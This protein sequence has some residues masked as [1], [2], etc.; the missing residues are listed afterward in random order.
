MISAILQRIGIAPKD[1]GRA[2]L[3]WF[4]LG[5]GLTM[6]LLHMLPAPIHDALVFNRELIARGEIWRA[7]TGHFVHLSAAHLWWNVIAFCVLSVMAR[8]DEGVS[9]YRQAGALLLGIAV[10]DITIFAAPHGL[11]RYAGFSGALNAL[12]TVMIVEAWRQHRSPVIA[13]L[14]CLSLSKIAFEIST[15]QTLF[16]HSPWPVAIQGHAGGLVAGLLI[17]I[18]EAP[19]GNP[20]SSNVPHKTQLKQK[21]TPPLAL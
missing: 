14:A 3:P 5:L 11:V 9:Y 19:P 6:V 15:G 12:W 13:L 7:L 4:P 2:S 1:H 18:L 21:V 16:F 8:H 10:I 17:L 20:A